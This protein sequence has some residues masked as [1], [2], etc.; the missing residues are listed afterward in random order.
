MCHVEIWKIWPQG[1]SRDQQTFSSKGQIGGLASSVVSIA[2]TQICCF[3]VKI[4]IDKT[5]ENKPGYVPIEI[6]IKARSHSL[7]THFVKE[8]LFPTQEKAE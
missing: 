7:L 5:S 1:D 4:A 3:S 2:A 6:Y 8:C